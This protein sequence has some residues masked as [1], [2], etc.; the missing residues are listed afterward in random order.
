M[1]LTAPFLLVILACL[2]GISATSFGQSGME[3][4]EDTSEV[5]DA[6][7]IQPWAENPCYWQYLGQPVLLLG[8]SKDDNLFQIPDLEEHLDEIVRAGG[9]YIRNT[10]SDR[11]DGGFEVYP[12]K[13]L[14]DGKYDLDDWNEEYWK[15]FENMLRG[16]A[17][18]DIIVQIESGTAST[19]RPTT[20]HRTRTTR[21][22][23]STIP[24]RR[25]VS[26]RTT[27]TTRAG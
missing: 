22:T 23:T 26:R 10:M 5:R 24:T 25:R 2:L 27:P 14:A 19:T 17:A 18:R 13:P 9:N 12:F 3:R 4:T 21:R 11:K 20:G 15:R 7:R 6:Q 1:K 8:G 16:T